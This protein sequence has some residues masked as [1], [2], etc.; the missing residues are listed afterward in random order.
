MGMCSIRA[1]SRDQRR[2]SSR[3]CGLWRLFL[4]GLVLFM[5]AA[6]AIIAPK[7]REAE[8]ELALPEVRQITFT[9][10]THFSSRTLLGVMATQPRPFLQPWKRGEPYNP[11]TLQAD[12]LRVKKYY[13]DRGFLDTTVNT[14]NV[15]EDPEKHAVRI[16][17]AIDEGPPT[18]VTAVRLAGTVPPE[19][20]PEPELLEAMQL[21]PGE[22]LNKADFDQSRNLLLTRLHDASYARAEVVPHTA[23][24]PQAHTAEVSFE[25]RPD[26]R[27]TIG[28]ISIQGAQQVEEPAIRRQLTIEEGQLYSN[29]EITASADAI[30]R[31][32]M[33][34]AV[35][36]RLLNLEE[37]E[38]PLDLAFDLIE[39]KP[40]SL[41]FGIGFST[42]EQFRVQAQWLFRNI[43]NVADQLS[44][45]GRAS[46][47][48]QK[49]ETRFYMPYF[50]EPHTNFT[51]TFY[52]RNE[53][54]VNTGLSNGLFSTSNA[55]QS[56]SLFSVGGVSSVGHVFTPTLSGSAGLDISLN[57]FR[58]V[59]PSILATEAGTAA[60]QNNFLVDQFAELKWDT[61]DNPL[62][63]TRGVML[64]GRL[65]N[66]STA[67]LSD[68]SFAKLLLEARHYQSL[69]WEMILATRL[70][71][72]S[73]EPY[74]STETIPF[75]VRFFA[76]G[77]GS[78]RGFG[79]N[80]LGPL[81]AEGN[82]LGGNSL[83]VGSIELRFPVTGDLGGVV[84]LDAGNVFPGSFTYR[85]NDLR[86]AVGPGIRYNT[87]IGPIRV[88]FGVIVNR[89]PGD[90]FGRLDFS[91]GQAF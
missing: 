57:K 26:G 90:N 79:L 31:L 77:P 67:L 19:L 33:F 25:L 1:V 2:L 13:F 85:L 8:T 7:S 6:C 50:L 27:T 80:R 16:T 23:V 43:W 87:P 28:H 20:P 75:N 72:G 14:E 46:S 56:F 68:A 4:A 64:R 10:N 3:S 63:P 82:P 40:H 42:V 84:F 39:R 53:Q 69:W 47:I 88:D 18:L 65:D 21:R 35:T 66:S 17:I 62:N 86:Y 22:R 74:G 76:G 36:P 70:Q 15:Q 59:D 32:G 71:V 54:K 11:A 41:Q 34:Q 73:I 24:D 37:D 55:Q 83:L 58:N 91:I 60:T 30:Y 9:G 48:E 61:S 49:L 29:K 89:R 44:F 81:D 51:Q 45:T 52:G 78:V 38:A 5:C 12:L